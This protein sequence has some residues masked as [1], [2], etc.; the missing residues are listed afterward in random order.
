[1][2][3]IKEWFSVKIT[4]SRNELS[5][6]EKIVDLY[7][8]PLLATI[9]VI[10]LCYAIYNLD[11]KVNPPYLCVAVAALIY[12][13]IIYLIDRFMDKWRSENNMDNNQNT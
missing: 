6:W 3:Y 1:M 8:L 5:L 13:F 10:V 11:C 7:L 12:F 2:D 4:T 9:V